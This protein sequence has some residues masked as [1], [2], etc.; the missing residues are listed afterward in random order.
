MSSVTP[1]ESRGLEIVAEV[2]AAAALS[3][4]TTYHAES[5]LT[6]YAGGM[7]PA[8]NQDTPR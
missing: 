6:P 5:P 4:E 8:W 3:R 7:G 1:A 2:D